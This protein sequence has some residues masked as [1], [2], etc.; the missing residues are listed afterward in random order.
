MTLTQG[1]ALGFTVAFS[2]DGS[3]VATAPPREDATAEEMGVYEWDA[4]TGEILSMYPV[5]TAAMYKVRYSPD[6]ELL[7]AGVQEGNV[8]LWDTSSGE[9]V[10]TLTGHTGFVGGLAFSP[11]GAY[12]ASVSS[13][14]KT[15][16]VWDVVTGDELATFYSGSRLAWSPDSSRIA[17]VGLDR[18][19]RTHVASTEELIALARSRVTR[20]LTTLECQKYLHVEE[21]PERP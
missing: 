15:T 10:R 7:A 21:C 5:E 18:I 1:A 14:D 9:L 16:K 3:R 6:G 2:P 4:A 11:D 20:G 19:L 17:T 8:F 13:L 12:L